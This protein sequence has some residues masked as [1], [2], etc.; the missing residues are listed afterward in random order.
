[1]KTKNMDSVEQ[2][3]SELMNDEKLKSFGITKEQFEKMVENVKKDSKEFWEEVE[4]E[5]DDSKGDDDN[6]KRNAKN[7][8]QNN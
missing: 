1:M 7:I 5:F 6:G 3:I 2:R 8:H 4:F